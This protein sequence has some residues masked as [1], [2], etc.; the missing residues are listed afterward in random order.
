MKT[1]LALLMTAALALPLIALEADSGNEEQLSDARAKLR[2]ALKE[3]REVQE[4]DYRPFGTFIFGEPD[5]WI[6]V[7]RPRLG[8][9]IRTTPNPDRDALGAEVQAV[10]PGGPAEEAG[11]RTGD[12]ITRIDGE[13]LAGDGSPGRRLLDLVKDL[14]EGQEVTVEYFRDGEPGTATVVATT[15]PTQDLLT[16][17]AFPGHSSDE[18]FHFEFQGGEPLL[19]HD[20]EGLEAYYRFF[21]GGWADM[22]L[23]SV[24]SELGE[25]FGVEEGVLVVSGPEDDGLDLRGGDILLSIDGRA[26]RSPTHGIRILRSYESGERVSIRVRRQGREITVD[27]VVPERPGL[28]EIVE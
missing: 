7:N 6:E 3:L 5:A 13:E 12:I 28:K 24:D 18:D 19:W 20:G 25:Y 26:V 14:E 16:A 2:Q 21:P 1:A 10:T 9:L 8:V 11:L 22:E 17:Y 4:D 23:V 15:L 27:S